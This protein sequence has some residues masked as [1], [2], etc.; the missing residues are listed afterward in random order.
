[1]R[2]TTIAVLATALAACAAPEVKPL[3]TPDGKAGYLVQCDGSELDWTTCYAEA[4][5]ACGGSTYKVL[6]SNETRTPLQYGSKPHRN[7]IIECK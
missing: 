6:N 1:M 5:K 2:N 4:N 3:T 7:L